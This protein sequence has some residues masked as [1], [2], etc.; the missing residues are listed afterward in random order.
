MDKFQRV[1][2]SNTMRVLENRALM[3][4]FEFKRE[5]LREGQRKIHRILY[6]CYSSPN[7]LSAF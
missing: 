4:I 7:I 2:R 3:I 6:K 5:E 1:D